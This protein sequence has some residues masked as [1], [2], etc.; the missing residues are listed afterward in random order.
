MDPDQTRRRDTD[1]GSVADT[2]SRIHGHTITVSSRWLKGWHSISN[3][4]TTPNIVGAGVFHDSSVPLS[5]IPC[6]TLVW[7]HISVLTSHDLYTMISYRVYDSQS[8]QPLSFYPGSF[9]MIC[10]RPVHLVTFPYP[11]CIVVSKTPLHFIDLLVINIFFTHKDIIFYDMMT[12]HPA[13]PTYCHDSYIGAQVPS[14]SGMMGVSVDD[15]GRDDTLML[16][17]LL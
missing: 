2:S 9:P 6:P 3:I 12:R 13:D 15:E 11:D 17:G 10:M 14:Y 7:M 1:L 5:S 4:P 16:G 8:I